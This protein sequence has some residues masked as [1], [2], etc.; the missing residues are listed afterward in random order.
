MKIKALAA[1]VSMAFVVA[2]CDKPADSG[3]A[4]NGEIKLETR[5]QKLSYIF[6]QNIG[7]QFK[8]QSMDIDMAVFSQG[9]Q[10][11]MDGVDPRLQEE[12][13]M[14]TLQSFQEEKMAEQQKA[15]DDI[16]AKNKA[17]GDAF[18]AENAKKEGVTT[19]ESGLQYKVLK[20]G[21][22][23]KPAADAAVEVHYKGTLVDGT[24]FD[25]SFKRGVPATF[26]VNEVIPGWTEALLLMPEGSKWEIYLPPSLAYGPGGAGGMI[27]PEQTLIFEV[28][29]LDANVSKEQQAEATEAGQE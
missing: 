10:D 16:S 15:F 17:E 28:E 4:D 2:A 22:G 9:I 26:G 6:G 8:A 11:A 3:G 14:S 5:Q 18:L 12:E 7:N 27:G 21:E 1:V 24:E 20:E 19:L 29:L 13:I 23:D 25:S